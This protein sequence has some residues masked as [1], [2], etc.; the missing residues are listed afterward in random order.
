LGLYFLTTDVIINNWQTNSILYCIYALVFF[1]G[2]LRS[3]FGPTIFSLVALLVPKK[4]Y[5]TMLL[6]GAQVLGKQL[7]F[8]VRF[9][10]VS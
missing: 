3:F 9:L 5:I 1:G 7:L 2:F 4:I 6:L 8:L 10:V